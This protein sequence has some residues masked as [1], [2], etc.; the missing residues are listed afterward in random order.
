MAYFPPLT[1]PKT[2]RIMTE[3][4]LG[5]NAHQKIRDGEWNE[6][7]N[8]SSRSYPLLSPRLPRGIVVAL[9]A[10]TAI[11]SIGGKIACTDGDSLIYDGTPVA[12]VVLSTAEGMLDKRI[13]VFGAYLLV[14]PD[15]IY[16]NTADGSHGSMGNSVSIDAS[17]ANVEYTIAR[18][19][20]TDYDSADVTISDTPPASPDA[21][22]YW[23]DTGADVHVLMQYAPASGVWVEIPTVYTKIAATGIGV[24]L[25]EYDG[26][27]IS[28]C[29]YSGA[30]P[31]LTTQIPALNADK[32]VMAAGDNYILVTGL[33]DGVYTQTTGTVTVERKIPTMDYLCVCGNRLWGCHYGVVSGATVNEIYASKLGDFKNFNTFLGTSIDSYAATVGQGGP[34]TG[35]ANHL[36]YPV[37]FKEDVIY[38]VYG[39]QPSNFQINDTH[40]RGV[41]EGSDRSVAIVNETLFYKSRDT[42][43]AY[44][45]ALPVDVGDAFADVSYSDARAGAVN[46]KYY[47]SMMDADDDW[48]LFVFDTARKI[49]HREDDTQALGFAAAA[50]EIYFIDEDTGELVTALGSAGTAESAVAWEAVS[51]MIGYEYQD[52]KY[53]SRFN[54]RANLAAGASLSVYLKYNS[55]TTWWHMGTVVGTAVPQTFTLPV[56]PSRCDHLQ[57]KLT[58]TGDAYVY[59]IAKILEIGGD[60]HGNV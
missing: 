50:G 18:D 39:T 60:G 58:G 20:G 28:G 24:G 3:T 55:N 42:I 57:M 45:G 13:Y 12:D 16:Y 23:I 31:E 8:L 25:S 38:K 21:G 9:T 43:C 15:N 29:A 40:C 5:F 6:M 17:V 32:I 2:Y 26:V 22:D 41:Q 4:F 14:T 36:G 54:I 46:D 10:P 1:E 49:W 56:R 35:A 59:S 7:T 47:V 33:L 19:D 52:A 53:L 48:H 34:F 27:T 51:G 11:A 44:D 37:F 30:D